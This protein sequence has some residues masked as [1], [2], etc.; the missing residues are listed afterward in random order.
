MQLINLR[1]WSMDKNLIQGTPE[2]LEMRKT[3]IG[4]SDSPIIMGVNKFKVSD[5][6][7]KDIYMLWEEKLGIKEYSCKNANTQYGLKNEAK[8]KN[9]YEKMTN[10]LVLPKVVFHPEISYMMASLDG[11]D[12]EGEIFVEIKNCNA[13]DHDTARRG[14]VPVHY[15]PQVQHQLA[16]TGLEKMHYFSFHK[17]EGIIVEVCRDEKYI[18]ELIQKEKEFWRCVQEKI[19]PNFTREWK[20]MTQSVE[21]KAKHIFFLKEQIKKA[22]KEAQDILEEILQETQGEPFYGEEFRVILQPRQ[23]N[24]N[25]SLIPELQNID[26]NRYRSESSS[27]WMVKKNS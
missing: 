12:F 9:I 22:Q 1:R 23:G 15:Y 19:P 16:C 20:E 2:W 10:N 5:G 4:A 21:I 24:I 26:L 8:A 14:L 6:R 7:K 27:Y 13:E 18:E 25:Y 11:I 3:H 17:E